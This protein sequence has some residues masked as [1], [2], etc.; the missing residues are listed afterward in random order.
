M[1]R[2]RLESSGEPT[3]FRLLKILLLAGSVLAAIKVIFVDYT[4]DEE[5]QVVMAYRRLM[6]DELFGTMWEPHQ[7]S[8]F[9]C[10]WLMRLFLAVT[11]GT[12]GVVLFLRVCTTVIQILLSWWLYRVFCEY[13]RREYAFMLGLAYFNISPKIIQIPEFS[14]L[15]VWFFTVI[16]LSL[17]QYYQKAETFSADF[18]TGKHAFTHRLW[19]V[20]AGVGMA[21]E[22]LS[23]PAC[24]FLFPFILI[25]IFVQSGGVKP[26]PGG[27]KEQ[28]ELDDAVRKTVGGRKRAL[29]DCFIFAGVC[30]VSALIWLEYV[31]S[32][33]APDVF[34]RNAGYVLSADPTHDFSRMEE[35]KME[36]L[37]RSAGM[38]VVPMIIIVL[39]SLFA[40]ALYYWVQKRRGTVKGLNR[41]V[42]AVFLVL[43]SEAV[44]VFY[45][46]VLKKGYEEPMVHLLV[47]FFAAALV[48]RPADGRKKV[49][50]TGLAGSVFSIAAVIFLSDLGAW[51]AIPHGM[52]GALF[53]VMI[54]IYALEGELG[55]RSR[56]WNWILLVSLV[57]VSILGKG[58]TLRA[59]K[60]ETNTI[61]GIR[62]IVREGPAAGIFTNYMQ[63]YIT[64]R[65]YEEFEE[66][67]EEGADCLI[68]NTV[69]GTAG[70][71]PY[72]FRNCN[73]CHFSVVD[74][75]DSISYNEN[76]LT[77]WSLYPEK[78][79]DVIVVDCWYGQLMEREDS[80]IMQYIEN[81][82][83]YGRVVDGMYV[84]Y[85]FRQ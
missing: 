9:A 38:L 59:G 71:S 2:K 21:F 54:L 12:T 79:P 10:V 69:V 50:F 36:L 4:L 70:T 32:S 34:L 43:A 64:N 62:G 11:G 13:T 45:W 25:C 19:L 37:I 1:D 63:A 47:L 7:T 78:Q 41:S 18:Q 40:G 6:G 85:Y 14:N 65:T 5:Y 20:L 58:F 39:T 33:V 61:L 57:V 60:T 80:W 83:N 22:V 84:R 55:E 8:A 23:Y 28:G 29:A 31:L 27:S 49:L 75:M 3:G 53:A 72:M 67:V 52:L 46:V 17:I 24:L 42:L 16:V 15:Q 81:D 26:K 76:L 35:S 73:I 68:V 74:Y 77:Y 48:W 66:Y 44:Q 30:G 51:Y 56:R 82:F